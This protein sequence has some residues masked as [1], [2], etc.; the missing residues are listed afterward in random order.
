MNHEFRFF[1]FTVVQRINDIVAIIHLRCYFV[2]VTEYGFMPV[3]TIS[4][5]MAVN[6]PSTPMVYCQA[7]A[8]ET[9]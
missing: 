2:V 7:E 8:L 9:G 3:T 1:M 6:E 4:G 5:D